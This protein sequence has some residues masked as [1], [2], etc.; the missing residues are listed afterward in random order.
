MVVIVVTDYLQLIFSLNQQHSATLHDYTTSLRYATGQ[1]KH[2]KNDSRSHPKHKGKCQ[3][4]AKELQGGKDDWCKKFRGTQDGSFHHGELELI[5]WDYIFTDETGDVV[6]LGWG[7]V[8]K[9]ES[10][11]F[12]EKFIRTYGS[13][14]KKFL[15]A[16]HNSAFRWTCCG[17][18]SVSA[19]N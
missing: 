8:Y 19:A 16:G 6:E 4:V 14:K 1:R 5:T 15:K 10:E 18:P 9:D 3:I 12:K 17:G 13:S 11:E 2:W 7:N